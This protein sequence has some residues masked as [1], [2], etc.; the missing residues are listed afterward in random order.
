MTSDTLMSR[1]LVKVA[2]WI[3]AVVVFA[4]AVAVVTKG[5]ITHITFDLAA[6]GG[7]LWDFRDAGYFSVRA[8]MDGIIPWDVG[9]YFAAYPVG[10]EFPL[11]PP[12]YLV[13]HAPFQ[14]FD[15]DTAMTVAFGVNLVAMVGFTAWSLSLARYKVTPLLVVGVAA[16]VMVSNGGRNVIYTG[17]AS[18]LFV[19][20]CYLALTARNEAV[21]AA[22]VFIGLI[23]PGFGLPVAVLIAAS[24]RV[25]RSILG[26]GIA[27]A[28]SIV[29]MVPFVIR[30]GGLGKMLT[31]LTD[32]I[33]YSAST[34]WMSLETTTARV[35]L[36]AAVA[37]LGGV[38]PPQPAELMFGIIVFA[39]AAVV[40]ARRRSVLWQGFYG[41]AMVVMV[42]IATLIGLYHAFYDLVLLTLPAMLLTRPDFAGGAIRP[43]LRYGL[44]GAVLFAGFN[45]FRVGALADVLEGSPRLLQ[46]LSPGLTGLSLAI[47]FALAVV[48]VSGLPEEVTGHLATEE[49]DQP[50]TIGTRYDRPSSAAQ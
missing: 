25:K 42:C 15:L 27:T 45:P 5:V 14:L 21:G 29:M 35:D 6:P 22:G 11:L 16:L 32:N 24:G 44:L 43:K 9:R 12:M 33:S 41:D 40:L 17:Q 30:A 49:S 26:A 28:V 47:A 18:L 1:P 20:G 34:F 38:V 37:A 8:V 13:V 46:I 3:I 7:S 36:T 10:Q 31:I 2:A 39:V 48:V 4:L 19:A 50:D 23:K